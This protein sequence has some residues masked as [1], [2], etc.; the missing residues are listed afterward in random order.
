MM[1]IELIYLDTDQVWKV[2]VC[3]LND[4]TRICPMGL[5]RMMNMKYCFELMRLSWSVLQMCA[6]E[7]GQVRTVLILHTQHIGMDTLRDWFLLN[8]YGFRYDSVCDLFD[9][10]T[11]P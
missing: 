1:R 4:D 7:C 10:Y 9:A 2:Y 11:F 8:L 6:N 5:N 3:T